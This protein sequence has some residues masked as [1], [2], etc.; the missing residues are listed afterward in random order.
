M[1][2]GYAVNPALDLGPRVMTAMVGYGAQGLYRPL[3]EIS[4]LIGI[5]DDANVNSGRT[6]QCSHFV[7]TIGSGVLSLGRA[8]AASS[9]PF[10]MI[11]SYSVVQKV[12]STHREC[13]SHI[14]Y[15]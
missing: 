5:Y 15:P 12:P 6:S 13:N 11:S 7:T 10:S 1:G 3:T 8:V 9:Q 4:F 14:F 2:L